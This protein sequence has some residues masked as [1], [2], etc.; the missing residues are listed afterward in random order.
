MSIIEKYSTQVK[1]LEKSVKNASKIIIVPHY[2][3]DGDAIG[4]AL[5]LYIVLKNYG[6]DVEILSPTIYPDFLKWLPYNNKIRVLGKKTQS[7]PTIFEGADLLIGVDFNALRRIDNIKDRFEASNA[8]K[9]L[10]DH[11]PDPE[12]FTD[13]LISDTSYSS[14]A[15]LI[16][17]IIE[18]SFLYEYFDTESATCLYTG[19]MTDTGSLSFGSSNP[20]T[21]RVVG[22][23][24]KKGVNK[25]K[26]YDKVYN[27]FSVDRMRFMGH[28]MLNRMVVFPELKTAYIYI[29]AQ[30]R[31][32]FREKFGDTENFV[33][34]PL[35]I[36][37]II[38]SAIFI[39]R[40]NFVKISFRSKGSFD[41]NKFSSAHFSGGGHINAS[42][43]ESHDS[44]Q[45]TTE[46][47]V[48]IL[49]TYSDELKN[50]EY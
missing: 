11:H 40:D 37:G 39:E 46:R 48:S 1:T 19:I 12:N 22:E 42:G 41:T 44:L 23:L 8:K 35:G 9:I 16:Y 2:N 17:E 38:F 7:D 13:I 6:K 45:E 4:S 20:N 33:N 15:E 47:F 43:G 21:Y 36:K 14:T 29:T 24:L 30:D 49:Q 32:D 5:G 27:S 31:K 18:S 26:A 10:I 28:I 3:P 50:Y 34:I 25:D